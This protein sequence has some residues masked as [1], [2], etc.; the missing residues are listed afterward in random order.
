[1]KKAGGNFGA[2]SEEVNGHTFGLMV[3]S[4]GMSWIDGPREMKKIMGEGVL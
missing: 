4:S 1:M 3:A 2:G